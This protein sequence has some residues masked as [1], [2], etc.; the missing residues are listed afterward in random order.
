MIGISRKAGLLALFWAFVFASCEYK[1]ITQ[2]DGVVPETVSYSTNVQ[3]I[4]DAHC[5]SCHSTL[6]YPPILLQEQSY[7]QLVQNSYVDVENPDNS[8]LV[9]K[10][11]SKHPSEFLPYDFEKEI[12]L[13]WIKQGAKNN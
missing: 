10:V 1:Y 3:P 8:V 7:S 13:E 11:N 9:K 12:M 6:A 2:P 4:F 5:I